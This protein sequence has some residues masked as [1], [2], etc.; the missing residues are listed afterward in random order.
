[1]IP[2]A[3]APLALPVVAQTAGVTVEQ[4]YIKLDA[5]E[6]MAAASLADLPRNVR[7]GV[8]GKPSPHTPH[9]GLR[10]RERTP[11]MDGV[12]LELLAAA[13][14]VE[15]HDAAIGPV[16]GLDAPFT[17][18]IILKDDLI[19][20]CLNERTCLIN[21]CPE[22]QGTGLTFFCHTGSILFENLTICSLLDTC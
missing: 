9:F 12:S 5:G 13:Q 3:G 16:S 21:R 20:I 14:R 1:M 17:L 19:D 15:L 11:F 4:S 2:A 10:V 7:I 6:G 8:T 18:E 22:Q